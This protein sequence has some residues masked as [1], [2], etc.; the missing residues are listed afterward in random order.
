MHQS[1]EGVTLLNVVIGGSYRVDLSITRNRVISCVDS[2]SVL[3]WKVLNK[4]ILYVVISFFTKV[5]LKHHFRLVERIAQRGTR[6]F[7]NE[8]CKVYL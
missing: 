6:F 5:L 1:L 7:L 4:A 8:S 3:Y 2:R